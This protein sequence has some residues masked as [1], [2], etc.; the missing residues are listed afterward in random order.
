MAEDRRSLRMQTRQPD[1]RQA[2]PRRGATTGRSSLRARDA[3]GTV[4]LTAAC[5]PG[6]QRKLSAYSS[7][8]REVSPAMIRRSSRRAVHVAIRPVELELR[9]RRIPGG[10]RQ[11]EAPGSYLPPTSAAQSRTPGSGQVRSGLGR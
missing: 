7:T 10:R 2:A 1:L 5:A 6:S 3:P 9:A 11:H 8:V 4:G